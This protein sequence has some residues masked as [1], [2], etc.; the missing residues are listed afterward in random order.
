MTG[1]VRV[2]L[3]IFI[4]TPLWI[5]VNWLWWR[6][7]AGWLAASGMPEEG[8]TALFVLIGVMVTLMVPVSLAI[9]WTSLPESVRRLIEP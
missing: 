7:C 8:A 2:I 3:A 9:Y 6:A 1:L 5:M 4:A